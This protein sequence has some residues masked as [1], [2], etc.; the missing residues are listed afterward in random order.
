MRSSLIGGIVPRKRHGPGGK[1]CPVGVLHRSLYGGAALYRPEV[2]EHIAHI[3]V[4]V[5]SAESAGLQDD[6]RKLRGCVFRRRERLAVH[7][8]LDSL[9]RQ[10]DVT[11]GELIVVHKAVERYS[12]GVDVRLLSVA[13]S[14]VA[15]EV[16]LR[17]DVALCACKG[18]GGNGLLGNIE[19]AQL[20]DSA[21]R[22]KEVAGFYVTVDDSQVMG[23]LDAA[24]DVNGKFHDVCLG[25]VELSLSHQLLQAGQ[26]LHAYEHIVAELTSLMDK[27]LYGLVLI[28]HDIRGAPQLVHDSGLIFG[29]YPFLFEVVPASGLVN[30]HGLICDDRFN[31]QG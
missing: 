18:T 20:V 30:I 11:E 4:P 9:L 26:A 25:G 31:F 6:C 15:G 27:R 8:P 16:Y 22:D 2:P 21:V 10:T 3:L 19:V 14:A 7:S 29:L 28:E 13:V 5:R 12:E 23:G 17:G 24:A 1:N